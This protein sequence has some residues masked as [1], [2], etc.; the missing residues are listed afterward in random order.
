M[1]GN[2]CYSYRDEGNERGDV[3][4]NEATDE[5]DDSEVEK[6]SDKDEDDPSD[7]MKEHHSGDEPADDDEEINK[8]RLYHLLYVYVLWNILFV[9]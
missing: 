9:R 1:N 3:G 5:G 6:S 8:L 7:K 2:L 4:K